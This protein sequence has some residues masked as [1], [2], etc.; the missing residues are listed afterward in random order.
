MD[1]NCGEPNWGLVETLLMGGETWLES[2]ISEQTQQMIAADLHSFKFGEVYDLLAYIAKKHRKPS[3]ALD[4]AGRMM[5]FLPA[6]PPTDPAGPLV[7]PA[8]QVKVPIKSMFPWDWSTQRIND[9]I[10]SIVEDDDIAEQPLSNGHLLKDGM[11]GGVAMR[12]IYENLPDVV[13]LLAGYPVDP[14][15]AEQQNLVGRR[16]LQMETMLTA[17][18]EPLKNH[19]APSDYAINADLIDHGVYYLAVRRIRL[20][21]ATYGIATPEFQVAR[22]LLNLMPN[23]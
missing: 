6:P 21:E 23:A 20:A 10:I 11:R 17:S 13:D 15:V 18:L 9:E 2:H 4:E 16:R 7:T 8:R 5:G 3:E 12:V 22:S 19:L 14:P 1:L